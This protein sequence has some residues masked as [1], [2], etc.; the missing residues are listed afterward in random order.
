MFVQVI[1]N[2]A[3]IEA[4]TNKRNLNQTIEDISYILSSI[5][6]NDSLLKKMYEEGDLDSKEEVYKLFEN[7]EKE[8]NFIEYIKE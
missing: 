1:Y 7:K 8:G 5:Q 2:Y 3:K 4:Y 6:F